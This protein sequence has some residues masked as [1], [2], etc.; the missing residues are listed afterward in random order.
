MHD[1]LNVKNQH[2]V[3]YK[4]KASSKESPKYSAI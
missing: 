1:N 3:S 2:T 4:S